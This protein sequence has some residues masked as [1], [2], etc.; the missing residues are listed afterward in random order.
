[1]SPTEELARLRAERD[2]LAARVAWYEELF[3]ALPSACPLEWGL[4]SKEALLLGYMLHLGGRV[5]PFDNMIQVLYAGRDEPDGAYDVLR[6]YVMRARRKT[7]A[8]GV[9]I[10]AVRGVGYYATRL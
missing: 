9:R 6:T 4:S 2:K 8:Y 10:W 5:A 1:M 3:S 7:R